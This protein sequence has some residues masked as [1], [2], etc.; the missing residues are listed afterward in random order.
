MPRR[1]TIE[2]HLSLD[3]LEQRYRRAKD[4]VE[5]SHY[6]I[7]WLLVSG[8]TTHEVQEVTAYSLRWIRLI[9]RRYNQLGPDRVG[10][11]RHDN[12]G[13][14][15]L[16][17]DIQQA[18]LLQALQ[19]PAPEGGLWNGRK[20]ADWI[21]NLIERPVAAQRGWEYLRSLEQRLRVP[22]PEHEA[23]DPV[24]QSAWKKTGC[25]GSSGATSPSSGE[26]GSVGNCG[27]WMNIVWDSSRFYDE[28]GCQSGSNPRQKSIGVF[29]GCG[30]MALCIQ[31]REKPIGGF[32]PK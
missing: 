14:E 18:Q 17:D 22:R 10:D 32:C 4:A 11:Q 6:Q 24:E 19:G 5:R 2:P 15:S 30:C 26:G 13:A 8:K 31:N 28:S 25:A 16:L 9:A 29:N 27:Q 21:A 7:V 3:E 1:I 12:P 23:A 20:V